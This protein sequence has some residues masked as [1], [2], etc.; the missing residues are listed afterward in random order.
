M[1]NLLLVENNSSKNSKTNKFLVFLILLLFIVFG[2]ISSF[3]LKIKVV[4][5]KDK[6]NK[7]TF[8]RFLNKNLFFL[9]I[10]HEEAKILKQY[11]FLKEVKL[12]KKYLNKLKVDYLEEIAIAFIQSGSQ[13]FL[14][15]ENGKIVEKTSKKPNSEIEIQYFQKLRQYEAKVGTVMSKTEVLTALHLIQK[16]QQIPY[17]FNLIK[18]SSLNKVTIIT[19]SGL[20]IIVD[21]KKDIAKSLNILQNIDRILNIKGIKPRIINIQAEKPFF[22]L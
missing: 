8:N 12:T 17:S 4:E 19:K 13:F 2:M 7:F 3:F 18:I 5:Y 11:P 6:A 1:P 15:N 14:L 16:Q 9:N 21:S 10:K 20:E 22:S